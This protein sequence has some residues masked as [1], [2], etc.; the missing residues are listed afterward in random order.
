MAVVI[1]ASGWRAS[2]GA[3]RGWGEGR[4]RAAGV[5]PGPGPDPG[6]GPHGDHDASRAGAWSLSLAPVGLR[7][8][9]GDGLRHLHGDLRGVRRQGA[10]PDAGR[11][12]HDQGAAAVL[13]DAAR[14]VAVALCVQ[15]ARW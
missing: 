8:D 3:G 12:E 2:D 4:A 10:E 11:G 1:P 6:W 13:P 9:P 14:D 7:G 5:V 15:R